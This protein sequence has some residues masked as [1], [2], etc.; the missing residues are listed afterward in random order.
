MGLILNLYSY[1]IATKFDIMFWRS[2]IL[3]SFSPTASFFAVL[4]GQFVIFQT[5]TTDVVEIYDGSSTDSP[6]LSSIYGSHS[7]KNIS[8]YI[9]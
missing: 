2:S 1:L 8:T 7:G 3:S 4:F 9:Y 6:L 5:L